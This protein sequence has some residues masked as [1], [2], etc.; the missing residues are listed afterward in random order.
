MN[1]CKIHK[2]FDA[3]LQMPETHTCMH[4]YIHT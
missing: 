3:R 4:A 2:I 1:T